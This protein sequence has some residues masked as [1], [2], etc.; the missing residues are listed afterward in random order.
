MQSFISTYFAKSPYL[1][2]T[3][4]H[5]HGPE[6][7]GF[8]QTA[9]LRDQ[10][11]NSASCLRQTILVFTA[12]RGSRTDCDMLGEVPAVPIAQGWAADQQVPHYT[13]IGHPQLRHTGFR[14][15]SQ[16]PGPSPSFAAAAAVASTW[17][18]A[19]ASSPFAHAT[20]VGTALKPRTGPCVA[21]ACL[22]LGK[23]SGLPCSAPYC[24]YSERLRS[25][26]AFVVHHHTG[27][28]VSTCPTHQ[29]A[30]CVSQQQSQSPSG[31]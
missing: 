24:S 4:M 23:G 5:R 8:P 1:Y 9:L 10:E 3:F 20:T 2:T 28:P 19:A 21:A 13:G 7:I 22:A 6:P 15:D 30:Y 11:N 29:P 12:T 27:C 14:K 16:R 17:P 25:V 26:R 18:A 31:S